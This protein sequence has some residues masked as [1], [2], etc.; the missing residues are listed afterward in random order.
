MLSQIYV[1]I[2]EYKKGRS[3]D[4]RKKT[5]D[6]VKIIFNKLKTATAAEAEAKTAA[7]IT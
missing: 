3:K 5:V 6:N 1:F 7:N 2:T 4:E